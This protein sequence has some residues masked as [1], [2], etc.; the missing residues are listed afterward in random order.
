ML[1]RS[2]GEYARELIT[3]HAVERQFRV[4]LAAL[5]EL[6]TPAPAPAR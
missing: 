3:L 1:E 4:L 6:G 2:N 5:R